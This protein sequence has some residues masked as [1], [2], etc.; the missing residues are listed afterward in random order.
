MK[1]CNYEKAME[2]YEKQ[3]IISEKL[4]DKSGISRAIGNMGLVYYHQNNFD[5]AMECYKKQII[6]KEELGDKKGI[7]TSVGNMGLVFYYQGNYEKAMEC[8]KKQLIISEELRSKTGISYAVGNMGILYSVRGNYEKALEC[9]NKAI[10][11]DKEICL[12]YLLP[13]HLLEKAECFYKMKEYGK[14]NEVNE[15]CLEISEE[16]KDEEYIFGC[17]VRITKIEF[18]ELVEFQK[19]LRQILRAL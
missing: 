17:K 2:C 18:K 5:K 4:G 11:I 7:S 1:Q 14:A 6:I 13:C 10:K 12:K 3:L 8:Y 19:A 15:E 9:F 16:M